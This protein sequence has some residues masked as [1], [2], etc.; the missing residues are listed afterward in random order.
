MRPIL[1]A[2]AAAAVGALGALI[3]GE[4]PFTGLT[5]LVA[6]VIFG[7]F[8]GETAVAV[9]GRNEGA[10]VWL[11]ATVLVIG[12][13]AMT[14]AAW[15]STGRDLSFLGPAGWTSIPLAG[16]TAAARTGLRTVLRKASPQ[17]ADGSLPAEPAPEVSPEERPA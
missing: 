14:W 5:V 4:Y 3:L 2:G 7:L 16:A 8:I 13:A 9:G 17:P 12:V 11:T 10:E 1:A 15:I 6:A